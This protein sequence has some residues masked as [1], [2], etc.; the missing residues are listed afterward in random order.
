MNKW[1]II[2]VIMVGILGFL[3]VKTLLK[4]KGFKKGEDE[5]K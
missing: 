1:V 2:S 5:V 3:G 4:K